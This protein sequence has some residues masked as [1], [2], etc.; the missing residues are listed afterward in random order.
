MELSLLW[1][2]RSHAA[3]FASEPPGTLF[4]IVQGGLYPALRRAS[5]EGMRN[6]GFEGYAVGGLA[7]GEPEEERVRI[8]DETVPLLP[9]GQPR[10]LM[11]VGRPHD[12][13]EAV[14]RGIDLFD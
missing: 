5:A 9:A 7:V 14:R 11:G 8:L 6:I 1:A 2:Q 13:I 10:Y 12:I 4:G 3:Y